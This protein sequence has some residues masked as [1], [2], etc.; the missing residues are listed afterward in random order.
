MALSSE[1]LVNSIIKYR[2]PIMCGMA[3][4]TLFFIYGNTKIY[5]DNDN[6]KSV[7]NDLKEKVEFEALQEKFSTPFTLIFMAEFA[8]ADLVEKCDSMAVWARR[9]EKITVDSGQGITGTIHLGTLRVPVKG[10]FL[11]LTSENVIPR[12]KNITSDELRKRIQKHRQ[13]TA[14][15]ISDDESILGMILLV[16]PDLNRPKIV[17]H[18]VKM[19]EQYDTYPSIKTYLTGATS[20]SYLLSRSMKRDF[21]ILLPI[22]LLVASLLL[23]FIFRKVLYV[24]G[25]LSIIAIAVIWTFGIMGLVGVPFSVVTSVIPIILFPVGVANSIH[26]LKTYSRIRRQERKDFIVSFSATYHELLRPIALTSITTFFGFGSFVFSS[27]SW[28]RH[29]GIFTGIGVM[30]SLFLTVLLLPIFLYYE[31]KPKTVRTIKGDNLYLPDSFLERYRKIIFESPFCAILFIVLIV[32]CIIGALRVRYE[33]NPISLFSKK[34][35]IR[36]SDKLIERQFGGTRFFYILLKHKKEEITTATR[37]AEVDSIISY[38]RR[39]ENIGD[40]NSIMPLLKET[41]RLL[42]NTSI[43]NSGISLLLKSKGLFGKRFRSLIQ[44]R[45]TP[46]K[47]TTKLDVLCKNIP[48]F[49]YTVLAEQIKKHIEAGYPDWEVDVAGP[50]LLIDSMITLLIKTQISSITL[51]FFSVFFILTLLFRSVKVGFFTTLP[52]ILSTITVYALMGLFNVPVN[53]VTVII[54]NTCIGIGIDYSIHFTAGFMYIHKRFSTPIDALVQTM[55]N[56]GTVI[57][58]NTFVV[59]AGFFVLVFSS[60]PPIRNFGLFIFLSML[61]SS[62]FALIFLPILF[63][64]YQ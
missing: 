25:S 49:K 4:I 8:S 21:A 26:V 63:R 19:V 24:L 35:T 20:T 34:S 17:A 29:F 27:I 61:I 37:W 62:S 6:M 45:V 43:S 30:F 5:V 44:S 51:A 53:M 36:K 39:N 23:Y 46:D 56:K 22:C 58:F 41:S 52:M 32:V 55:K 60:F 38:I 42:S 18:V 10:G 54:M 59:G 12:K 48:G 11:G 13:F 7:P 31:P 40:V 2:I 1:N 33:S 16:N 28:T 15:Y 9:F 47:R 64:K 14:T 57:M 50:A 3:I